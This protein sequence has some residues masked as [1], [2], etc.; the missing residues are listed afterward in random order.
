MVPLF[1]KYVKRKKKL[2]LEQHLG[3]SSLVNSSLFVFYMLSLK[4]L[5][6]FLLLK[7]EMTDPVLSGFLLLHYCFLTI[8]SPNVVKMI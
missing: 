2:I 4:I 5:F 1:G 6:Y 3:I 7:M 8:T